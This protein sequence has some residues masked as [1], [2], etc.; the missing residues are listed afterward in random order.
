MNELEKLSANAP[1]LTFE[2][3][4]GT[5]VVRLGVIA[6]VYFK[7]GYT[8]TKKSKIIECFEKYH[9]EFGAHLKGLL[10][11]SYKKLTSA[12]MEK[13]ITKIRSSSGN[14]RCELH[15][16]SASSTKE[17]ASYGISTLNSREI[18]E[19]SERSYIKIVFPWDVISTD[20]GRATYRA[21]VKYL[22][23]QVEAEHGYG[24]LSTVLPFD[25]D[26]YMPMEYELAQKYSGLDVDSMPHS[27]S[28]ELVNNIKG[29]NWQTIIGNS[30]VESIGGETVL[31]QRLSGRG[32]I[33]FFNY[34]YGIIIQAGEYPQLGTTGENELGA[35]VAV[36]R[37]VKSVRIPEPDQIHHY[38]PYGNCFDEESTKRWY[39]RFD[40][41][42]S[43]A[44]PTRI[45]SN[46]PCT[47]DGYWFTPAKANSRRYF[48]QGELMP[49]FNDS[50]WGDTLWYWSGEE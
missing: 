45:E 41:D 16:T 10:Q 29:V 49:S 23:N 42:E 21:W 22:C 38:S 6:T 30:F 48:K 40:R 32:D 15:L 24:G 33:N 26:S 50:D 4:D 43:S 9:D 35:Y 18:H 2:L 47:K 11:D 27:L 25:Y 3:E 1:D 17:A 7:E 5:S 36:N 28:S 46:Q 8:A 20:E 14:D 34:D 31:R 39:A 19:N 13:A 37:I 12:S 44:T